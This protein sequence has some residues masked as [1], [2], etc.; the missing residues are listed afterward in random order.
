MKKFLLVFFLFLVSYTIKN[1][2]ASINIDAASAILMEKDTKRILYEKNIHS[3]YLTASIAKIMT[4]I[5]AIENGELEN[6][7]KVDGDT[8]KQIGSSIYL[9]LDQEVKLI[10]LIYGLMLRSGNDAAYLIAV[11]V[12]DSLDEFV[13]LMNET[14]KK[15]G[16]KSSSF[17]N[18]SGLDEQNANYST[19]YDMALLMAYALNNETFKKVTG[20]RNYT[21]K[22]KSGDLLYFVNKHRLI[23]SKD[24]VTGGKTGY[25][26]RAK[27][28]L[29]TSA[30]KDNME[31]IVV[32]FNCGND[33]NSHLALFD[34]GY[35]N[36]EM[37]VFARR[38]II[39]V[40]DTFY[41]TPYLINDLKYP[42]KADDEVKYVIKLLKKPRQEQIIGRADIYLDGKLVHSVDIYRYY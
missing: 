17:S 34:Y 19:A 36:Y 37:K 40:N 31:L 33:W 21:S 41:L 16:M 39:K 8:I 27:R 14:A 25:T 20:S 42:I 13:D 6:Y 5:V 4:A 7:Y 35:Q 28:T 23:Q 10:D 3:R 29:V 38:E 24:F 22:T 18:P 15:I 32:T 9:G 1:V 30:Y 2:S 12:S 26:E 11:S